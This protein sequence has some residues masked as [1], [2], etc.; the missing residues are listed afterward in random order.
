[1][2]L[3]KITQQGLIYIENTDKISYNRSAIMREGWRLKKEGHKDGIAQAWKRAKHQ[4]NNMKELIAETELERQYYLEDYWMA[5]D[6]AGDLISDRIEPEE[7]PMADAIY[8]Y[9]N[10]IAV[11]EE[12]G[13]LEE[14]K[15]MNQIYEDLEKEYNK[16]SFKEIQ[17]ERLKKL[18]GEVA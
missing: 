17:A 10:L 7:G 12:L 1:M 14:Q 5:I 11:M 2:K 15:K 13:M 3:L 16:K 9:K 8:D 4:M 6:V 18:L